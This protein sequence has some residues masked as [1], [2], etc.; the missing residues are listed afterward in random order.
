MT[1]N[2]LS[3]AAIATVC[4][5][6]LATAALAC[7]DK[8]VAMG[9]GV[10]FEKVM[11]SRNPGH[12]ILMLEPST[13]LATANEKFNLAGSLKL[14]GHEVFVATSAEDLREQRIT[15]TPDVILV[16]AARA[17]QFH[18]QP[19]SAGAGPSIMPV[20]YS[21]DAGG[22]AV[23][24][25][26]GACVTVASGRKGAQVLKAVEQTMKLRRRGLPTSCESAADKQKA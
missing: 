25:P 7:G 10:G 24:D 6:L 4:G 22:Q 20:A 1:L 8:L 18:F 26:E 21:A 19:V 11:V 5:A 9:G 13:G 15:V 14:A 2:R 12:I 3:G 17:K 23:T 16:D